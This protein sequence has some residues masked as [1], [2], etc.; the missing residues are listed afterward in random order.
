LPVVKTYNED[1]AD[2]VAGNRIFG[3]EHAR[4]EFMVKVGFPF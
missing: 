1:Q 2:V 3:D 4:N